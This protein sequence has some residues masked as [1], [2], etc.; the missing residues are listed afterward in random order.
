MNAD[1]F[2]GYDYDSGQHFSGRANGRSVSIYDYED[3]QFYNYSVT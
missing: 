3:G 1:Q 2:R